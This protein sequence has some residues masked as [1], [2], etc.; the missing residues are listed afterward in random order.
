MAR[1]TKDERHLFNQGCILHG[2][3]NWKRIKKMTP[4][5]DLTQVKRHASRLDPNMKQALIRDHHLARM[6]KR[7]LI[8]SAVGCRNRTKSKG[9]CHDH[10]APKYT[11]KFIDGLGLKCGRWRRHEPRSS[12]SKS[13][14]NMFECQRCIRK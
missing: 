11:C 6:K 9:V 3:G 10:G 4:T 1:W 8:C 7:R 14:V 5:R 2:W 12:N 13:V